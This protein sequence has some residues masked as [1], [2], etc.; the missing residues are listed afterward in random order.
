MSS[1]TEIYTMVAFK[2]AQSIGVPALT[3]KSK[4]ND[5]LNQLWEPMRDLVLAARV[6]PWALRAQALA[7]SEEA[8]S[9]LGWQ[10]RYAYPNDCLTA[11][12]VTDAIGV[13][14]VGRLSRFADEQ[15]L[16]T[17]M[18]SSA[19]DWDTGYGALETVIDT[20]VPSA[21]LVYLVR[22]E[23][24]DRYP[25]HFVQALA[26]RLA[27]EAAPALIGEVGLNSKQTLLQEYQWA[28]SEAGAHAKNEASSAGG[29]VTPALAARGTGGGCWEGC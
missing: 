26:C 5:V 4:I 29:Y 3:D 18:G 16:A 11:Y 27:A 23:D 15:Y 8:D 25:V 24:T 1:Q 13:Q 22:I 14:Q 17:I 21:V 2:V 28:L 12:A 9:M 19:Y 10:Y 20:N 7:I 6:W